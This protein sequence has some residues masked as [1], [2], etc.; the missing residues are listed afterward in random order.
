MMDNQYQFQKLTPFDSV[1]MGI[2]EE[3]MKYIFANDDIR[4]IAVSGVYGAGK[5]SV[6]ESYKKAYPKKKFMHISLAHFEVQE[7]EN[8]AGKDQDSAD[9]KAKRVAALEGKIINQLVHQI[10]SQ[11]I[12]QTMFRIKKDASSGE[13]FKMAFWTMLFIAI[14]CFLRFKSAWVNM[15]NGF[16]FAPLRN[17]LQFTTSNEIELILGAVGLFLLFCVIYQII[18]LQ[19]NQKLFKKFI[20]QGNQVE[21]FEESKDSYFDKYLNEVLYLFEHTDVDGIIFED[22]DRYDSNVIFEK[23]REINY[24][25]NRRRNLNKESDSKKVIRFFYLLKDDLFDSKDRT[26]FFDFILPIVPSVDASNALDKFIEYFEKANLLA[27]FDRGFLQKLS[28]YVDDMRILKNICNEFVVYH[29]RL[30]NSF[31]EQSNNKLLAMITYKNIFPKDFGCLQV[32]TGYVY[33]LFAEKKEF[34]RK[35]KEEAEQEI[36]RLQNEN[37]R[38]D[39]ELCDDVDELN[40]IYFSIN[41]Q[42]SVDNK[43]EKEYGSRKEFVKALLNSTNVQR[44]TI[45]TYSNGWEAISID[46]AKKAM[47]ENPEYIERKRLID[48]KLHNKVKKNNNKINDLKNQIEQLEDAYLK[49]IITRENEKEI[50]TFNFKNALNEEEQFA[51]I[52]RSPYFNLI[53]FLIRNGYLDETYSDYMTYFYENSITANDKTFLRG[54]AD[55][56]AKPYYYRLDNA[57]MVISQMRVIDFKDEEVLN[58]QLLNELLTNAESY[59]EQLQNFM[60]L[61]WNYEPVEFVNRFLERSVTGK[62]FVNMLNDYW[63]GACRWI[64]TTDGFTE[65]IRRRYV[66]DTLCSVPDK[67][68]ADYNMN[69]V[70][71]HYLESDAE[72]LSIDDIDVDKLESKIKLMN[73]EFKDINFETADQRLLEF[74]YEN[75]FFEINM[76]MILK[77]LE[78]YYNLEKEVDVLGQNLSIIKS[79]KKE[80]LCDYIEWNINLYLERL[81]DATEETR[82][83]DEVVCYVLN[84]SDVT[85]ENKNKYLDSSKTLIGQIQT[86]TD[87][88]WWGELMSR[89]KVAKSAENLCD[90]YFASGNGMDETLIRYINSFEEPPMFSDIDFDKKYGE[91]SEGKLF[92]DVIC[93]NGIHNDQY[94]AIAC[95]LNRVCT[96]LKKTDLGSE[97]IDILVRHGKLVMNADNLAIVREHYPNN[98]KSFILRN[99]EKYVNIVH[100]T[101]LPTSELMLL[102]ESSIDDEL[103]LKLLGYTSKPI[104]VRGK[105]YSDRIKEYIV[106]NLYDSNDFKPLLLMYP[107]TS[108]RM[109]AVILRL[110]EKNLREVEKLNCRLHLALL[111]NLLQSGNIKAADKLELLVQQ[112]KLGINKNDARTAFR[113]LGLKEF[114]KVFDGTSNQIEATDVNE[115]ILEALLQRNWITSYEEDEEDS[116]FFRVQIPNARKKTPILVQ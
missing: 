98:C 91:E 92:I 89:D 116:E 105:H 94:K 9:A 17:A 32:G 4:N 80:P 12:P 50:F 56:H 101:T 33:T 34:I 30:R 109:Q 97:K 51:E 22:I 70:I 82:D 26:K 18:L 3:A 104:A 46:A 16:S 24:L 39:S 6:I 29:E 63:T 115:S 13:I 88:Q 28:L 67:H 87:K 106:E 10:D 90:Y 64:I 76:E 79:K 2:Y 15:I 81:L 108:A 112:I 37:E 40:A 55:K 84:C 71:K 93:C 53:K 85:D 7:S 31:S 23:L 111:K 21:I 102:L 8:K 59:K 41:G 43:Q 65:Q 86:I 44:F 77:F 100:E 61:I 96:A 58:Y 60:H 62:L 54:I 49:D 36:K 99:I 42:L 113:A 52:K 20:F 114:N 69:N 74:V 45:H 1:E 11:D 38:M 75:N 25:L 27:L 83:T 57:A 68:F 19:K 73:V 66:A 48:Q 5:S 78:R 110:A 14:V 47:E 35:Q 95:A 107:V 72:F 103:K